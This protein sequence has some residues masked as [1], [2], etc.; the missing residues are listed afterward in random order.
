MDEQRTIYGQTTMTWGD[1]ARSLVRPVVRAMAIFSVVMVVVILAVWAVTSSDHEWLLLRHAPLHALTHI[2][3]GASPAFLIAFAVMLAGVTGSCAWA[4][5][6]LPDANRRLA[7]EVTRE[8]LVTRDAAN[9]ALTVP[10]SAIIRV[11]NGEQTM[12]LRLATG[13]WR[14][15]FWR[16]FVPADREQIMRWAMLKGEDAAGQSDHTGAPGASQQPD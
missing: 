2:A 10:W 9:F 8:R 5:H 1:Q 4:F 11:R 13:G 16:A 12:R 7:Y 14:T 6:R 15:V 3:G